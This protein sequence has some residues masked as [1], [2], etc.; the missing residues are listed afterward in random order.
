MKA[1]KTIFSILALVA[2][3]IIGATSV[4]ADSSDKKQLRPPQ[5]RMLIYTQSTP[6]AHPI[7]FWWHLD[8]S[9]S[10]SWDYFSPVQNVAQP[11]PLH[12]G[13][14]STF[15][16]PTPGVREKVKNAFSSTVVFINPVALVTSPVY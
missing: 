14:V 9:T 12:R 16:T 2:T 10:G 3:I 4:Q 13:T 7:D 6:Y 1:Y 15:G 8:P 11:M 5:N